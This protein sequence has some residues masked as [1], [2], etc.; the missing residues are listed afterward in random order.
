[1]RNMGADTGVE[2]D[3]DFFCGSGGI[4]AKMSDSVR[5]GIS[6]G[7][8]NSSVDVVTPSGP[9]NLDGNQGAIEVYATWAKRHWFMN[10]SAGYS[11]TDWTFDA[12]LSGH[13]EATVNGFIASVQGGARFGM[14][15]VRLGLLA[16]LD[17]DG[18]KCGETCFVGS[19][20]EAI[21]QLRAK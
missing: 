11:T 3:Q 7:Y 16:E 2:A 4:D 9:G 20:E 12:P 10:V 17:Y 18:T 13:S 19:T 6:G 8:G 5:M 15:P 21:S 1:S 14:G